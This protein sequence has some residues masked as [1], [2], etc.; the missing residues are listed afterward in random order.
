M[1]ELN[2]LFH[3]DALALAKDRAGR[4]K[5]I[6]KYRDDREKFM[7]GQKATKPPKASPGPKL[8]LDNLKI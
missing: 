5:V 7:L 3:E 8:D 2:D 1:S 4:A 6:A